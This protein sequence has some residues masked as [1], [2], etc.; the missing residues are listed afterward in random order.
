MV[1]NTSNTIVSLAT[2]VFVLSTMFA[3][4]LD[5]SITQLREAMDRWRLTAVSLAVNLV[6]VPA[7]AYL[8]VREISLAPSYAAGV[9]L[10]AA[11][12][13][14]P[15]GPKL[16][17]IS[18]GDVAFRGCGCDR[19]SRLVERTRDSRTTTRPRYNRMFVTLNRSDCTAIRERG[20]VANGRDHQGN[21]R[22]DRRERRSAGSRS[23]SAGFRRN[24]SVDRSAK[25][26][27]GSRSPCACNKLFK[28]GQTNV[29][30]IISLQLSTGFDSS[31]RER[32]RQFTG[33]PAPAQSCP[34]P[35]APSPASSR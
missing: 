25:S 11:S 27:C 33:T 21:S 8:V 20:R 13:G 22:V 3:V 29:E 12:P 2:T 15:F 23:S 26:V 4:G 24:R 28:A 30:Y 17:E 34:R 35:P 19:G 32:S 9:V 6:V 31:S 1:A 18:D 5:L 10:L 7:L 16:A 14:T